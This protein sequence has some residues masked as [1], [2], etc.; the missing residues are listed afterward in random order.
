LP[1][2]AAPDVAPV[3][4]GSAAA[5]PAVASAPAVAGGPVALA[6]QGPAEVKVGE[7]FSVVVRLSSQ[8]A[9]R[10]MPA[11]IGF[12][13]QLFQVVNV[14]EGDFFRQANAKSSFSQRV[15]AAQ[16]R[17]FVTAVRQSV[18][19]VDAGINGSGAFVTLTF[20]A[21]KAA[22]AARLQ[23][24]SAT[25]EPAPAVPLALPVEHLIRVLP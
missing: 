22:K 16:G 3:V 21:T 11:L 12:D 4:V 8:Q 14:Q 1:V 23:L 2:T 17:V 18:S 6:W 19:G 10:G 15:D 5:A 20:K 24:L 25:P 9:L 13:P 7:Q